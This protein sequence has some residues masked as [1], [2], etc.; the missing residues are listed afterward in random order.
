MSWQVITDLDV[1]RKEVI[2]VLETHGFFALPQPTKVTRM[3]NRDGLL[4][5][6]DEELCWSCVGPKT[7]PEAILK[8]PLVNAVLEAPKVSLC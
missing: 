6:R 5:H 7:I 2:K 4:C 1:D 8:E 3:E